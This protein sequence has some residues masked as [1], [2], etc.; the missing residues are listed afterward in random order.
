VLRQNQGHSLHPYPPENITVESLLF[1]KA[2][3]IGL[4]IAAPVGPIGL[5]CIQ[6]TL[7]HG[8]RI[9]FISGL[10]AA[11]ADAIYGAIGAFGLAALT[12][13]FV[14]LT[15]PLT[16]L[17]AGFL[18]WLGL[19]TWRATPTAQAATAGNETERA[20]PGKA[21]ASVLALT[22]MNP[23]TILSFIAV[24]AAIGGSAAPDSR[25]AGIMV[26][27]VFVGSALWWLTLS[28]GIATVR[29]KISPRLMQQINRGAGLF[30]IVF[31]AWQLGG[32]LR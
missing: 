22:L 27:G 26:L 30:L 7:T 28:M 17:G 13:T 9:G 14:A 23:A 15:T 5:L 25:A 19:R 20:S 4:S 6:R 24:F 11:V 3:L 29:H 2:A 31:A 8:M 32:L 21:F 1:L 18:A 16:V 12:Q 10:G